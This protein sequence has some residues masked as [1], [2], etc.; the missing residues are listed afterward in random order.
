MK[1]QEPAE[2]ILIR[3]SFGDAKSYAVECECGCGE[4]T[5]HVWVEA[6]DC[7]VTVQTFIE[8]KTDWWTENVEKRYDIDNKALQE[9]DWFWKGLWNSFCTR[10]RLTSD[11]WLHGYAKYEGTICMSKQQALNYSETLKKAVKDVEEF[12]QANK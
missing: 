8:L 12:R 7:G 4:H 3:R 9:F 6:D 2:G 11:I 10:L 5:H 1:A